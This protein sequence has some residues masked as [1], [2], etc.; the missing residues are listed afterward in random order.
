MTSPTTLAGLSKL[1]P[2]Y[3]PPPPF[4]PCQIRTGRGPSRRHRRHRSHRPQGTPTPPAAEAIH[5]NASAPTTSDNGRGPTL[6]AN[7]VRYAVD[8]LLSVRV[9]LNARLVSASGIIRGRVRVLGVGFWAG[10]RVVVVDDARSIAFRRR[11]R[12]LNRVPL[13]PRFN[14]QRG[15]SSGT[16]GRTSAAVG[17]GSPWLHWFFAASSVSSAGGEGLR[18]L[19]S[20]SSGFGHA[21]GS[22]V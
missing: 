11:R 4:Y 3:P 15:G 18:T 17:G 9:F 16:T 12:G 13:D 22:S 1:K 6:S 21:P 8:L 2:T 7:A 20:P 19:R 10:P 5:H 14:C